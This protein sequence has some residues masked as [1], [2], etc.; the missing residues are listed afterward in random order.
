MAMS[1]P[2]FVT[3]LTVVRISPLLSPPLPYIAVTK[4]VPS[5]DAVSAS[6]PE[7]HD[8]RVMDTA[9]VSTNAK[10]DF[11]DIN[12]LPIVMPLYFKVNF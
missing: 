3:L 6:F 10:I 2:D 7:P 12:S 5:F 11:T 9:V 8:V 4:T 1:R